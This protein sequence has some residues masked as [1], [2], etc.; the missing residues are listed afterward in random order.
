VG[1]LRGWSQQ[2]LPQCQRRDGGRTS[3]RRSGQA[4]Q[5]VGR[6]VIVSDATAATGRSVGVTTAA[7][8]ALGAQRTGTA[9]GATT[10]AAAGAA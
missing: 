5:Q 1:L 6:A 4:Q 7:A 3:C 2:R 8:P 10:G 9:T